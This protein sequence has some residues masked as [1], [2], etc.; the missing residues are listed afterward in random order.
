MS[1][2]KKPY[3]A[4]YN[5]LMENKDSKVS[6]IFDLLLDEM[7]SKTRDKNHEYRD[8]KLYIFCYY[9][10]E[11]ECVDD[12]EYGS[13]SNTATGYNTMCKVGVNCWTKQQRDYKANRSALL[14]QVLDQS[15]SQD[16]LPELMEKLEQEKNNILSRDDY[17]ALLAYE[18]YQKAEAEESE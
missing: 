11:W 16:D 2:I 13:K 6:D 1:T 15:V 18:E 7:E 8:G 4:I 14:E 12:V 3:E 9:H 5:I 10:K 17:F